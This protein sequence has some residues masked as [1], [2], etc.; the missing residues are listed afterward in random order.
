[1]VGVAQ[2]VRAVLLVL[3]C[4]CRRARRS[5]GHVVVVVQAGGHGA[6]LLLLLPLLQLL[7]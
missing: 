6:V 7:L 2:V 4:L 5:R 1:V 3:R